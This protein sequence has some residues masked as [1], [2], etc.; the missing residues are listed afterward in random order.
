MMGKDKAEATTLTGYPCTFDP[1]PPTHHFNQL[2]TNIETQ[3]CSRHIPC[4]VT[5]ETHKRLKEQCGL[6]KWDTW[7]GILNTQTHHTGSDLFFILAK[8]STDTYLR[9][10]GRKFEDIGE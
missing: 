5:R 7:P 3:P 1:D 9:L 2:P 4:Q 10:F 8:G 6:S